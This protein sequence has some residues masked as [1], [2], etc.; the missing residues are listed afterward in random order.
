MHLR[1]L[2]NFPNAAMR[3]R[4]QQRRYQ[5][6]EESACQ[7]STERMAVR[8]EVVDNSGQFP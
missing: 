4:E 6:A 3:R 7:F 5:S 1:R 8:D 2:M